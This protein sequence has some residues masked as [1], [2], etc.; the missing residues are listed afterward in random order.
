MNRLQK[1]FSVI[2]LIIAAVLLAQS[3]LA[4]SSQL[5][6]FVVSV[7]AINDSIFLDGQAVLDLTITNPQNYQDDFRISIPD[8]EWSVQS[9]P[10]YQYFSGVDVPAF[11]SETVRLLLKPAVAFPPGLRT[12]NINV[13]SSATK[14]AQ[15]LTT[16]VNIRSN[17]KLILEYLAA[18]SRIV[19]I[20]PEI[21]P[22]N[23]FEIKVNL[24]NRNPKNI[25]NL[26]VALSSVSTSLI[27]QDIVTGLLPL[28]S[29][30]V[31]ARIKLDPLTPP[32]KD[33]L[34]VVLYVDGQ[35]LE[36][37]IFEKFAVI[38]Y[39]DIKPVES[40][41]KSRFL[42]SVNET[43]YV[44][45][46]NVK[47]TKVIE[48]KTNF[49]KSL[50]TSS[51]PKSFAITKAGASYSAWELSLDPQQKVTIRTVESYR[52]IFYL[53]LLAAV[54]LL[55]YR[56]F[57]SPVTLIKES[58][59]ISYKEGG[60]S[61]LKVILRIKNR[62][63]QPYVRVTV[64]DRIPMIAQVEPDSMGT[65]KP[66]TT[67]NDGR[68][69]TIK[70]EIESL[71]KHEERILAYKIKSRLSILGQFTLPKASLRFYTEKNVKFVTSSNMVTIKP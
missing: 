32:T 59:A 57:Q 37:T 14:E 1:G 43:T 9:D 42:Q 55:L 30:E 40:V 8:V 20:P 19:D 11:S 49:L 16:F 51:N 2:V 28:E 71:D 4:Q 34:K 46:G 12:I 39:S 69:A 62:S 27:R 33:T 36:P 56:F 41:R 24:I 52:S 67:F 26:R 65:L 23:E 18:V 21:D 35:P 3:A 63:K 13:Q 25:S 31:S 29:K 10:L 66:A 68:G 44:N 45:D 54:V 61:E 47:S 5:P 17:S 50:F 53:L 64:A 22:R 58:S 7:K 15:D 70:W 38:S 48:Y 6:T 60:I